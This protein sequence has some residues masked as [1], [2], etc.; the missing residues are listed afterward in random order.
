MLLSKEF[1]SHPVISI[2]NRPKL[3]VFTFPAGNPLL[4]EIPNTKLLVSVNH[5]Y[6]NSANLEIYD[7]SQ[8]KKRKI[9]SFEEVRGCNNLIDL[10]SNHSTLLDLQPLFFI[11]MV[12]N[13]LLSSPL[14]TGNGDVT[15]NSRRRL[16]G[17][18]PLGELAA[19]HL[20][21]IDYSRQKSDNN[22]RLL[23]KSRWLRQG[24]C[25]IIETSCH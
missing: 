6:N 20:W 4:K 9:Y 1:N 12:L 25:I 3:T 24:I 11:H 16:L 23:K 7:L 14:V 15:F 21:N 2:S 18:I 8:K 13:E 22:V 19:Y 10:V 17:A 5:N